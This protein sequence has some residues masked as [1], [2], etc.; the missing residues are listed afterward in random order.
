MENMDTARI[1][2]VDDQIHALRG[3]SRIMRGAGYVAL[4]ASNETECLKLAVER[5]PALIL[6]DINLPDI[7]GREVCKRIKSDPETSDIYVILFSSAHIES[8]S[9]AEGLEHGADSYIA[10]PIPNRELLARVKAMLR[11]K[12]AE[13][14][15][16][17]SE[18]RFR[19]MFER[20]NAV[21]LLIEP[22]TGRIV[23]A[24]KAAERFYGY[25]AS[26]LLSMSVQDI[27]ALPPDKVATQRN[28]ALEAQCKSFIFP[29]RLA[30]GEVRTV[31]VHSSPI[32][33]NGT[34]FLFSIVNDITDRKHAEDALLAS[35]QK[36]RLLSENTSDV[37]WQLDLDLRFTYVNPAVERVTGYTQHEWIG[38]RL[39][40]H[41][42]EENFM[43]MAQVAS[44]AISKQGNSSEIFVEAVMLKKNKQPFPVEI[45]GKVIHGENGLSVALQGVTRD[46]TERKRFEMER[47]EIER[48]VLHTQKL[49]SL[50]VMAGGIAHDFNNLLMTVLGNL[51]L[52]LDDLPSDAEARLS[53]QNAIQAAERSAELSRQMQ[54]YTGGTLYSPVDLDLNELLEKNR[55]LLK[56]GVPGHVTLNLAIGDRLPHIKGDAD[57]IQRL[58]RNI[59]VNASEAIGDTDGEVRLSTGVVDCD[60]TYLSQSRLEEKPEPGL[61][62]FLE[63]SDTGCGMDAETL[64]RLFDPFFT[65]K[66]LGRGLGMAETLGIVKGHHGALIVVS[67]IGKGT[68]IRVLFPEL[69]EAQVSSVT[70]REVVETKTPAPRTLK[71][72]KTILLVEDE[73]GVRIFRERLND[74]DLVMLDYAMP[75]MNGVEALGELIRIKPDVKV[76][77]CS[78]YTEDDVMPSFP[79]KR[80]AG[81]LHKPYIMEELKGELERL[82]GWSS[83][84]RS[85]QKPYWS[86]LDRI[87]LTVWW[88]HSG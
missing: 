3:V 5:K 43:K 86:R 17:D 81:V 23:D 52:D 88:L 1:L 33:Q 77:L 19:M 68:T 51:D 70:D 53:V 40:E 72:R 66:F 7:D 15:L 6:L 16:R 61:F 57:Q 25:T 4:E 2:I 18:E 62:I 56:L 85:A 73:T 9:Q 20:H 13:R 63:V 55:S 65:T 50:A 35:E 79:G 37:I 47:L 49:E 84:S 58:V 76:M 22:V 75:R 82:L 12:D 38:S 39:S 80:P 60:E 30:N 45:V 8:D 11:L 69:K 46:I 59:L 83:K 28:L 24:N 87:D 74:I 64:H 71:R 21:M 29:H 44:A 36:Y 31:E 42:D 54:I 10:R 27:N 78:G 34:N 26:Q 14:R 32:E 67:Q 48:K 41:C